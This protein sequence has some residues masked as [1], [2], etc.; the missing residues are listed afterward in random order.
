LHQEEDF[1]YD[2][3]SQYNPVYGIAFS[4]NGKRRVSISHDKVLRLCDADD[5]RDLAALGEFELTSVTF[6]PKG[7]QVA[8]GTKNNDVLVWN[9]ALFDSVPNRKLTSQSL[10]AAWR[11]EFLYPAFARD[12]RTV[13]S[14]TVDRS[15]LVLPRSEKPVA[16][17]HTGDIRSVAYSPNGRL[18]ASAGDDKTIRIWDATTQRNLAVL[19]GHGGA[20]WSVA[21]SPDGKRLASASWDETVRIW[22]V[23]RGAQL[24]LL[25]G[26]TNEVKCVVFSPDGSQ[27]ASGGTDDSVRLWDAATLQEQRVI[28]NE[29]SKDIT[30][31]AFSPNG[32]RV[33]AGDSEGSVH[34]WNVKS[35]GLVKKILAYLDYGSNSMAHANVTGIAVTPDGSMLATASGYCRVQLW[36]AAS[37]ERIAM[38]HGYE[39]ELVSVSFD[40]SGRRILTG[41]STVRLTGFAEPV[42]GLVAWSKRGLAE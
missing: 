10:Y 27:V 6:H 5:N 3:D 4:P 18:I 22:D 13:L 35:G 12:G 25:Q 39:G 38:L 16:G 29:G 40:P 42:D 21:F 1:D 7:T 26:H 2:Y 8:A 15:S 20:V 19:N 33:I 31:I 24:G 34:V 28:L 32:E 17:G 11:S 37:F 14:T 23:E 30:A 36:D 9:I 41:S